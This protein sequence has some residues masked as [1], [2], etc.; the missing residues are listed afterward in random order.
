MRGLCHDPQN[1]SVHIGY[2]DQFFKVNKNT[3]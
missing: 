1:E 2:H 3:P